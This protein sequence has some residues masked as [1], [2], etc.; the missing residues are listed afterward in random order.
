MPQ[1]KSQQ[2]KPEAGPSNKPARAKESESK[3]RKRAGDSIEARPK[4]TRIISAE[5]ID[6]SDE[7]MVKVKSESRT[8]AGAMSGLKVFVEI[9]PKPKSKSQAPAKLPAPA[10]SKAKPQQVTNLM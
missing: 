3:G 4:K 8:P 10:K 6:D 9:P 7:E 2:K 5:Y 1:T